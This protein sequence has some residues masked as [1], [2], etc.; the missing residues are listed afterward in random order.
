MEFCPYDYHAPPPKYNERPM[1]LRG[2]CRD[3]LLSPLEKTDCSAS[4]ACFLNPELAVLD[5]QHPS[6]IHL[7]LLFA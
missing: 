1:R 2:F 5:I 6:C 3:N 7:G 4:V